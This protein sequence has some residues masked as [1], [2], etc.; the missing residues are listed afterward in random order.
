M[1]PVLLS[2]GP[3]R[4]DVADTRCSRNLSTLR[5]YTSGKSAKGRRAAINSIA[6]SSFQ[7]S[8]HKTA[9]AIMGAR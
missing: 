9:S 8:E 4:F 3:V 5:T 1:S 2:Y 7:L 6:W